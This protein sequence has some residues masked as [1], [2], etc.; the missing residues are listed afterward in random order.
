[1]IKKTFIFFLWVI[2]AFSETVDVAVVIKA[3]I[4]IEFPSISI[5]NKD[6][7]SL[8]NGSQQWIGTFPW[9]YANNASGGS[10][11]LQGMILQSLGPNW[12]L[13]GKLDPPQGVSGVFG[14]GVSGGQP[15]TF[16]TSPKDF[17]TGIAS[18]KVGDLQM[19]TLILTSNFAGFV[20]KTGHPFNITI[21]WTVVAE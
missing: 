12:T 11:K 13:Q 14:V 17:V 8:D 15:I 6:F 20:E 9:F 3:G 18:G 10:C 19:Q 5:T 21:Q 1:M 2:V 7:I 4:N 16:T